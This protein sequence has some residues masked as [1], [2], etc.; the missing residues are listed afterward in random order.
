M[1][2]SMRQGKEIYTIRSNVMSFAK[3]IEGGRQ[4]VFASDGSEM[5]RHS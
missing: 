3:W 2:R 4:I 5:D 1:F